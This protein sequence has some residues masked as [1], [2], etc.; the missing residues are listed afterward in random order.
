MT[1]SK[2]TKHRI[3]GIACGCSHWDQCVAPDD[4]GTCTW[5]DDKMCS[6]CSGDTF[7]IMVYQ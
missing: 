7:P 6:R 1:I 2:P 4:A 5:A 3:P